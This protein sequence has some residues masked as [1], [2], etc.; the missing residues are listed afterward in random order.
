M[1]FYFNI[2][3]IAWNYSEELSALTADEE[4]L[5]AADDFKT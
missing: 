1:K 5:G 2:L 4:K 3:A